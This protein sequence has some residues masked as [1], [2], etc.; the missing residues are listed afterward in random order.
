[1]KKHVLNVK[2]IINR[3]IDYKISSKV[4]RNEIRRTNTSKPVNIKN[5]SIVPSNQIANIYKYKEIFSR[6]VN[7]SNV[8]NILI[9]ISNFERYDMLIKIIDEINGY[10]DAI[11]VDYI[12]FDDKSSY[13]LDK[14]FIINDEH[15]GKKLY[16]KTFNDMF[17][18]CKNNLYDTYVF[19]PNDFINLKINDI[20]EYSR[21]LKDEYYFFNI[22]NDGRD[23]SWLNIDSIKINSDV[24]LVY[25]T[26]CGFFTN[27]KTLERLEYKINQINISDKSKSSSG[28]GK[29]LSFRLYD[30]EIPIFNPIKSLAYHGNH[31]SIM[32]PEERKINKLISI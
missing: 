8:E 16:W 21:L 31:E 27:N 2:K 32:N 24:K 13:T 28:V 4:E 23:K 19:I 26:D 20:I 12:I 10:S 22:I 18:Y 7:T 9:L 1:M 11:N 29:Q 17:S 14:N 25:F 5:R 6:K 30:L 15:R 3:R